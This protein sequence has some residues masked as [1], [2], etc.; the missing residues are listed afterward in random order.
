MSLPRSRLTR[1]SA[2]IFILSAIGIGICTDPCLAYRLVGSE[3]LSDALVAHHYTINATLDAVIVV[4][5][6]M[7]TFEYQTFYAMGY[8]DEPEGELGKLHFLEHVIGGMGGYP[9]GAQAE[10]MGKNG[11][12]SNAR[13][14]AD[15]T[16][17]TMRFPNDKL[18]LA[19]EIDRDRFYRTLFDAE[20]IANEKQ[21]VLTELSGSSTR[22]TR[23]FSKQFWGLVYGRENFDGLG[24][25]ALIKRTEPGDLKQLFH[26]VLRR[27]KR[28]VV[29]I[30][31]VELDNVVTK[32]ADA[33]PGGDRRQE[34]RS[35]LPVFPDPDA[36]GER[37]QVKHERLSKSRFKKA[38]RIPALGHPDYASFCVLTSI[39]ARP[40]NS[41]RSSLLDSQVVS[42]FRVWASS[43]KGFGLMGC[44]AEMVPVRSINTV[45]NAIRSRLD[46]IRTQ[47]I[48]ESELAAGRNI[49]LRKQYSR[50]YD[51][52][53]MAWRFAAAFVRGS[54]PLLYPRLIRQI[55]R[56]NDDDIQRIISEHLIRENS[57]TLSWTIKKKHPLWAQIVAV[58]FII[59]VLGG[60]LFV[61]VWIVRKCIQ[62]STRE[63]VKDDATRK[64]DS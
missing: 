19:V 58:V 39:L 27:K 41:L 5:R 45:E 6:T 33:F 15:M 38:W 32:L 53:A 54:D 3:A 42:S 64:F 63:T 37:F 44:N 59:A 2:R 25:A 40:S 51:R 26:N 34:D 36:L 55:Q 29:V 12:N 10:L 16:Y 18:A 43:H 14:G 13:T 61:F 4:D 8:A 28:L 48:T 21:V 50:L 62:I 35:P 30:G 11:G 22:S 31:D 9:P 17:F 46:E 24:T 60:I 49:Q 20:F 57:I 1:Q 7:P 56:V 52:S 47:G 23:R